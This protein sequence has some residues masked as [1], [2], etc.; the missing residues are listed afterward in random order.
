MKITV[1][2]EES[3]N[4]K[5]KDSCLEAF[6]KSGGGVYP[7]SFFMVGHFGQSFE[8]EETSFKRFRTRFSLTL[9]DSQDK[10]FSIYPE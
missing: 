2:I 5:I 1:E 9:T 4:E 7:V 8:V 10:N 3:D 6:K